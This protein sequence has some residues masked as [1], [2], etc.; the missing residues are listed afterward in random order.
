VT[1]SQRAKPEGRV[2]KL[3]GSGASF[4]FFEP[5]KVEVGLKMKDGSQAG[6]APMAQ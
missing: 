4:E 1:P 2:T 5:G 3:T 6:A